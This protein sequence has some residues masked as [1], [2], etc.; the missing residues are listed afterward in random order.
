MLRKL[1]LFLA[2]TLSSSH[3]LQ[4]QYL[5]DMVDTTTEMGKG[6]LSLYNRFDNIVLTGYIQPQFQ[7]AESKGAKGFAGGDFA[8]NSN[9]R[10]M[11]RRARVRFDYIHFPK[12]GTGPSLQFVFQFDATERG[13]NVRDVWGRISENKMHLFAFTTGLF[14]RPFSYELNLSSGDRESPERGRMS[15]TLMKVERDLGAMI[16]FEPRTKENK[17]KFLKIDAGIFNG[18]GLA[19]TTDYDSHKDLIGRIVIK[20]QDLNK[21]MTLGAAVSMFYGGL[22][23]NTQYVYTTQSA[24]SLKSFIIDSAV[25]N[26]GKLSPRKYY[27]ADAQL[28]IEN[29]HG[30]TELR[31]E[32]ITGTQTGSFN[33]SETPGALFTRNE[34]YYIRKFS[35]A[36]FYFLQHLGSTRHQ[37]GIKYDWYD[38]NTGVEGTEIGKPGSNLNV[39]DIRFNTLGFGYIYFITE[40]AKLVLWFDKITNEK[41]VLPEYTGDVKD[42]VFTCRLQFR[43]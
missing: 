8:A 40:H 13:V 22:T 4:A 21:K 7:V 30:Y 15:Q 1:L 17:L 14:A 9:S 28:K 42:N 43:F 5:M 24:G 10:F 32:F 20:P 11:L 37:V 35:G 27:G 29:K 26:I 2:V 19:A 18:P 12:I 25:S 31:A 41:T 16:T 34:A 3:L 39:A 38:P 23:Q 33:S 6:M 36:Y